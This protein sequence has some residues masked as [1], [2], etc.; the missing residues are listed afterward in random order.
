[1]LKIKIFDSPDG[2]DQLVSPKNAETLSIKP[3]QQSAFVLS[4]FNLMLNFKDPKDDE[5]YNN[6]LRDLF[7]FPTFWPVMVGIIAFG[8]VFGKRSQRRSK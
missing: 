7:Y 3:K 5:L 8:F 1:M 2:G 4:Q 6:T